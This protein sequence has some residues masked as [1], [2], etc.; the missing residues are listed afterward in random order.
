MSESS[1]LFIKSWKYLAYSLKVLISISRSSSYS[2]DNLKIGS[3]KKNCLRPLKGQLILYPEPTA[4]HAYPFDISW[5]MTSLVIS[6]DSMNCT[7]SGA[8]SSSHGQAAKSALGF[9]LVVF[10]FALVPELLLWTMC[11][12]VRC[13]RC[14]SDMPN[15]L[16]RAALSVAVALIALTL[17]RFAK[18]S[19][20]V[21]D[22]VVSECCLWSST[23]TRGFWGLYRNMKKKKYH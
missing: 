12:G 2:E 23:D 1:T 3:I 14:S 8:F 16:L 21:V 13:S 19:P 9:L 10:L 17:T 20:A 4:Y 6:P 11:P 18:V 22:V 5:S 15:C 7:T